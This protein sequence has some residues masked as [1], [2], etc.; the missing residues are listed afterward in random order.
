M[1]APSPVHVDLNQKGIDPGLF[2]AMQGGGFG[3]LNSWL[4]LLLLTGFGRG[5]FG[6][7]GG[8]GYGAGPVAAGVAGGLAEASAI[9][10]ITSA[11]DAVTATNAAKD[12]LTA[13]I[14]AL[15]KQ[16]CCSTAEIIQAINAITPQMFQQFAT[17][18]QGMHS[19]F[20]AA[21]MQACQNQ[22]STIAAVNHAENILSSQAERIAA[23]NA[24]GICQTQNLIREEH[25]LT[26]SVVKDEADKTRALVG[27]IETDRLRA[28][29]NSA[30]AK[31]SQMEQTAAIIA[32]L[33]KGNG[34]S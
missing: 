17:L 33:G 12:A 3:G 1:E 23:A 9:A 26:R 8:Y 21:A 29:L 6:F 2:A 7:G 11:K 14:D 18:T 25:C 27:S 4:P 28:D 30:Q 19:G 20:S 13:N 31:V 24:L 15:S 16:C 34:N 22:A 5:G 10:S 32:A